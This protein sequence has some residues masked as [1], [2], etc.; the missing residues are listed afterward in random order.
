MGM[1]TEEFYSVSDFPLAVS[2]AVW[3]PIESI[4]KKNPRRACFLFRQNE[5][6]NQLVESY[7]KR[8]LRI[9]PQ[10]FF[11]RSRE[12]KSLLYSE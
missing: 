6:L 11:L 9:E 7:H 4:D 8:K 5:E 12:L 2:L 1:N 10:E 3:L